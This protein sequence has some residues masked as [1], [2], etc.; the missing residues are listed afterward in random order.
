MLNVL[1][2]DRR[3][4]TLVREPETS[5]MS[6]ILDEGYLVDRARAVL[7]DCSTSLLT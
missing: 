2:H 7:V 4:G 6:F 5:I 3:V 1:L